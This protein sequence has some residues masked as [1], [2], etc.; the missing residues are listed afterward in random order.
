ML[1]VMLSSFYT[2]LIFQRLDIISQTKSPHRS[3]PLT[4]VL[5]TIPP[6]CKQLNYLAFSTGLHL[7]PLVCPIALAGWHVSLR[8][9]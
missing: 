1:V 9:T 2:S 6:L 7:F 5:P 8:L 4:Q 3:A